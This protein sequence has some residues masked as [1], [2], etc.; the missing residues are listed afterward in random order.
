ME[1]LNSQE[2]FVLDMGDKIYRYMGAAASPFDKTA[3]AGFADYLEKSKNGAASLQDAD[4]Y[5]WRLLNGTESDVPAEVPPPPQLDQEDGEE[6]PGAMA[7][8]G[9][10]FIDADDGG[11]WSRASLEQIAGQVNRMATSQASA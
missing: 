3:A 5:F 2:C 1:A 11:G 10:A 8:G 4:E 9:A 7:A 6:G